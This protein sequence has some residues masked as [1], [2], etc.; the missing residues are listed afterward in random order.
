MVDGDPKRLRLERE[1]E[2]PPAELVH[3]DALTHWLGNAKN[4]ELF[5][6]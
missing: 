5:L 3:Q 4:I 1:L 2:S 6:L